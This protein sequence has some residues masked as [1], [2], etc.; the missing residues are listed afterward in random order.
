MVYPLLHASTSIKAKLIEKR[1]YV[2]TYWPNV[3]DWTTKKMLENY[4]TAHLISLPIDHRYT[5]AD[6]KRI[7]NVLKT[8][9]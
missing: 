8:M 1:I 6:M 4:L 5:H 2:A 7:I 9:L 3:F